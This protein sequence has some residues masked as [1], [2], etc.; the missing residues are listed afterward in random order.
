MYFSWEYVEENAVSV[1]VSVD[2]EKLSGVLIPNFWSGMV[3]DLSSKH[4][5]DGSTTSSL[6][7]CLF[8]WHMYGD[9][10]VHIDNN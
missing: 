4:L 5:H 10:I 7:E 2:D 8:S 3:G 1:I 6:S 9:C